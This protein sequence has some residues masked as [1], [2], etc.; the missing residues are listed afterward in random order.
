MIGLH[1]IG[2]TNQKSDTGIITNENEEYRYK[3]RGI[4]LFKPIRLK[5][6]FFLYLYHEFYLDNH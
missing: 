4:A 5:D 3:K 2:T 6:N 1:G